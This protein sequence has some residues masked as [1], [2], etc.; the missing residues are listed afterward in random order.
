MAYKHG[1]VGLMIATGTLAQGLNFPSQAVIMAGIEGSKFVGERTPADILNAQ[2]RSGRAGFYNVGLSILVPKRVLQYV[3]HASIDEQ[4]PEYLLLRQQDAC[5]NVNSALKEKVDQLIAT[6]PDIKSS[7]FYQVLETATLL[8]G[9]NAEPSQELFFKYSYAAYAAD[10]ADYISQG[11]DAAHKL[12]NFFLKTSPCPDWLP[13]LAQRSGLS[14]AWL[15][16]MYQAIQSTNSLDRLL[17]PQSDFQESLLFFRETIK[18]VH[19]VVMVDKFRKDTY[20]PANKTSPTQLQKLPNKLKGRVLDW[21]IDSNNPNFD[22]EKWGKQW[23]EVFDLLT[24]WVCGASFKQIAT[25]FFELP[26]PDQLFLFP[27]ELPRFD[28]SPLNHAI[29]DTEEMIYPLRH[30]RNGT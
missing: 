8:L 16:Q 19:S 30:I 22:L 12:V 27:T 24:A 15:T 3:D 13:E 28:T 14:I 9:T 25:E 18:E 11:V 21:S 6:T 5:L 29:N 10:S 26:I 20:K 23:D 7:D 4:T 1:L 17:T 2:G